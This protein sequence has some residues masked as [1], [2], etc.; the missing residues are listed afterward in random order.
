MKAKIQEKHRSKFTPFYKTVIGGVVTK[1]TLKDAE[2]NAHNYINTPIGVLYED[3]KAVKEKVAKRQPKKEFEKLDMQNA[4]SLGDLFDKEKR[5]SK[6]KEI[7]KFLAAQK[8][9]RAR[10][11]KKAAE[12][13]SAKT[14][15]SSRKK[16]ESKTEEDKAIA[17]A[18][19]KA[20]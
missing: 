20:K 5:N 14:K 9:R 3:W 8:K 17:E 1:V 18:L 15:S 12:K 2:E 19:E 16:K 13:L 10:L 4:D 11:E 6:S 7:E